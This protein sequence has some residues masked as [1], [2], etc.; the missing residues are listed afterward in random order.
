MY[1]LYYIVST[2]TEFL[3]IGMTGNSLKYRWAGHKHVCSTG[4]KTA[5]YDCMRKHGVDNFQMVLVQEYLTREE[6]SAA[7]IA[8]IE[9][10]KQAGWQ[11]LNITEGGDGG[12]AVTNVDDWKK[13][14][15]IA[16][17]GRKPA[18]GMKHT[19]ENK[20]RFS[21]VS[22]KY[23]ETNRQ[24]TPESVATLSFKEANASFGISRTHYYRLKRTLNNEQG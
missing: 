8:A 22:K 5:L 3:Y 4:K 1:K 2:K 10:G 24:Y 17:K 20:A 15:S 9:N 23:W 6:C 7:E 19:D 16:R 11:L 12:F 13:K 21:E 18:L 14:L